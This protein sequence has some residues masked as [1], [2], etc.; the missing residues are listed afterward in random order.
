MLGS[1]G[2]PGLGYGEQ[3]LQIGFC[4]IHELFTCL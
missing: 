4:D 1:E 3:E 2:S